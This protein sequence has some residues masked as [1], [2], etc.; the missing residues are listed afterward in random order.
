VS[1]GDDAESSDSAGSSSSSSS[2]SSPTTDIE[3]PGTEPGGDELNS[4]ITRR[5]RPTPS[6]GKDPEMYHAADTDSDSGE[7]T[8][9]ENTVLCGVHFVDGSDSEMS[10]SDSE[11]L[12][13]GGRARL[14]EVPQALVPELVR[15]KEWK[16]PFVLSVK[17]WEYSESGD[18]VF[19]VQAAYTPTSSWTVRRTYSQFSAWYSNAYS[20]LTEI[21]SPW[22]PAEFVIFYMP[23]E[24]I[25]KVCVSVWCMWCFCVCACVWFNSL[26]GNCGTC[27]R[28]VLN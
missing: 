4:N 2:S 14:R 6:R 28:I 23:V 18:V 20:F 16:P 17:K 27:L 10:G 5:S 19:T 21:K 11:S 12:R 9:S 13:S 15:H 7:S 24:A 22:P 26:P 1:A 25:E 3:L 8:S